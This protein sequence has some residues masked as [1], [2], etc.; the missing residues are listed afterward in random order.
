MHVPRIVAPKAGD[1][2]AEARGRGCPSMV[3][4][5]SVPF[6]ENHRRGVGLSSRCARGWEPVVRADRICARGLRPRTL[7]ARHPGRSVFSCVSLFR[8]SSRDRCFIRWV[9]SQMPQGSLLLAVRL[10][11]AGPVV[12]GCLVV[13]QPGQAMVPPCFI[14]G[15]AAGCWSQ[16]GI[17]FRPS[18]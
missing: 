6:G 7:P 12:D 8:S 3:L 15:F 10:F 13:N 18:L 1:L 4:R 5:P 2:P 16:S 17:A 14:L 11:V 9:Y